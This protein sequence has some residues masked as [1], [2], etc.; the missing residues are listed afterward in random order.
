[1]SAPASRAAATASLALAG[2][3]ALLGSLA[4]PPLD[5]AGVSV[6]DSV[7]E[8]FEALD[9]PRAL[10]VDVVFNDETVTTAAVEVDGQA[11]RFDDP[12]AVLAALPGVILDEALAASAASALPTNL[13]RLCFRPGDPVGC[14]TVDAEPFALILD[15]DALVA[16]VFVD[17][18]RQSVRAN[19]ASARL[20]PPP[21][22]ASA[23]LGLDAS[24][25][26][27]GGAPWDLDLRGDVRLGYGPGYVRAAFGTDVRG[28]GARLDALA[29]VHLDGDRELTV[30]SLPFLAG[31]VS[32]D[33]D[34][35]GFRFASSLRGRLDPAAALASELTVHLDRRSLVQLIVDG[36]VHSSE[37]LPAGPVA[38]DTSGLPDGSMEVEVR[39]VDPVSG[40][41]TERRLFTR[42]PL[43]PPRDETVVEF[44]TGVPLVRDGDGGVP[45]TERIGIGSVRF[46]RR[47][48]ERTALALSFA[49]LG[50]LRLLQPELVVLGRAFSLQLSASLGSGGTRGAGVRAAWRGH[51]LSAALAGDWFDGT[52]ERAPG[53]PVDP[54]RPAGPE[55][56][57]EGAP[58]DLV[59]PVDP[60]DAFGNEPWAP[61]DGARVGVSLNR[62]FGR[63]A[64][65]LQGVFVRRGD[66]PWESGYGI[67]FRQRL[68]ERAGLRSSLSARVRGARGR[69]GV[70]LDLRVSFGR[71]AHRTALVVGGATERLDDREDDVDGSG[72]FETVAGVEHRWRGDP[73]GDWAVDAG[74]WARA[75]RDSPAAGFDVGVHHDRFAADAQSQWHDRTGTGASTDTALRL[76]TR[77]VLDAGGLAFAGPDSVH[78]GVIV[79]VR[80]EPAGTGYDIVA[81][82]VRVGA[83]RIGTPEFV[84]LPPFR[85]Y[86]IKL[87]SHS[88]LASTLD[89]E[90][91]EIT[92]YPGGVLRHTVL[93][94]E[95]RLLIA[96][97][98][99]GRGELLGGAVVSHSDGPVV[100]GPEGLLQIETG[101]GETLEVR[102]A[103]GRR[104]SVTIPAELG[105]RDVVVL[106][107]PLVCR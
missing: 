46:A 100:L 90:H 78:S 77:V 3:L 37:S 28:A 80:G 88:L 74:A 62:T 87:R 92:L 95:R 98:V 104:C 10:L 5:A 36:Y 57:V 47:S 103:N 40:E 97:L 8:G 71:D 68:L 54:T 38:L 93:A 75:G 31:P 63:S 76:A 105:K 64:V 107:E 26:S 9:G 19:D 34:L 32:S 42:S 58:G 56:V 72:P 43:L 4:A 11:L 89:A 60:T 73:S 83:G 33:F 6:D 91:L 17:P 79:D 14:G 52:R 70:G 86:R 50:S 82:G 20:D 61:T 29:L 45:R 96:S 53:A 84:A 30:G 23:I 99:D 13:E 44:T 1:M 55:D 22:L 67:G 65:G 2:S 106:A 81:N 27:F 21:R 25:S 12:S 48:G 69:I 15:E 49:R 18:A 85:N 41:R 101:S 24:A 59:D 66:E 94:R 16:T 35:L 102:R 39:I 51:R 7:P